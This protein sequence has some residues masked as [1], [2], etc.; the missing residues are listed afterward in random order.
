[1][2]HLRWRGVLA[3][4][5]ALALL[6]ATT[7]ADSQRVTID[8]VDSV[9]LKGTFYPG[10]NKDYP[11]VLLLHNFDMKKG[12]NRA[13]DGWDSLATALQEKGYPVLSFDFRGFGDSTQ[14]GTDFWGRQF[15]QNQMLVRGF[16]A[17]SPPDVISHTAF[18]SLYYPFLVNDIAAAK[19]FLDRKNDTGELNTSSLVV[20]GAGEGATLGV[21]W[22]VSEWTRKKA[23]VLPGELAPRPFP[24]CPLSEPEGRDQVCG[25]WLG[26]SPT[27]AGRSMPLSTW[28]TELGN[29][30]KV[31]QLF[32]YG[33]EDEQ[34]K[35]MAQSMLRYIHRDFGE[36]KRPKE[37]GFDFTG[38]HAVEG[39]KLEGSK[40]LQPTLDTEKWI[41]EKYLEPLREK[42][43][44]IEPRDRNLAKSAYYWVFGR[45]GILANSP[46][47]S[48][49][50]P[51]VLPLPY[52][53]VQ[54]PPGIPFQ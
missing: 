22:M 47:V 46:A 52:F 10:K 19:A 49:K 42:R 51:A 3:L 24:L 1:M 25:I 28:M 17:G 11:C 23:E 15:P 53:R 50:A 40:L 48:D 26:I 44:V 43:G 7:Q 14:V 5:M 13:Q 31:A 33:K 45:K 37:K 18:H 54:V 2:Q 35:R 6:P 9:R 38:E 30:N 16:N 41:V 12:G 39:T 21:L 20:I 27:L 32:V 29:K 36:G 4:G 34:G 8:T